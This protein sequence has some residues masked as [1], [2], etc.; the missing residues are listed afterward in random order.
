[1]GAGFGGLV[2]FAGLAA[3]GAQGAA[4][5]DDFIRMGRGSLD[6][7]RLADELFPRRLIIVR[8]R[9]EGGMMMKAGGAAQKTNISQTSEI[10]CTERK[11]RA[12][13]QLL[14]ADLLRVIGG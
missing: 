8:E 1:M 9:R 3:A 12:S 14:Q 11:Q 7:W 4:A 10:R 5:G 13:S 2:G 6:A